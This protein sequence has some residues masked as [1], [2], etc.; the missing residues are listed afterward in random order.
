MSDLNSVLIEGV[1]KEVRFS[2]L[3]P[4]PVSLRLE[5]SRSFRDSQGYLRRTV[6]EIT[7][8]LESYAPVEFPVLFSTQRIRLVGRLSSVSGLISI[9]PEKI[10]AKPLMNSKDVSEE[11]AYHA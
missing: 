3:S 2:S 10:E 11:G 4:N 8:D 9:I 5:S 6:M 7:I 1:I